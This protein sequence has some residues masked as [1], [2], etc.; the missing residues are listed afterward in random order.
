MENCSSRGPR[1][2]LLPA[3]A[4]LSGKAPDG[5]A[6]L[7]RRRR[8][9]GRVRRN[10]GG[11]SPRSRCPRP[12][13]FF[14]AGC[15]LRSS[16]HS[17]RPSRSSCTPAPSVLFSSSSCC[18]TFREERQPDPRPIQKWFA[19]IA[20]LVFAI[21]FAEVLA[22]SGSDI[23]TR[24]PFDRA[25]VADIRSL[26]KLLFTQYLLAFEALSIL[27][28]SALVGAFVLARKEKRP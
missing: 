22:S 4:S 16:R 13:R 20:I 3:A 17:W 24:G 2:L 14:R 8:P 28:L 21:A 9:R 23:P 27:L 18:S 10:H 7:R 5:S 6:C 12:R 15:L 25:A 11:P 1:E 26:A 19:A